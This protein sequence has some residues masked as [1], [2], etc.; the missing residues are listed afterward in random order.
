MILLGLNFEMRDIRIPLMYCI[1]LF[2]YQVSLSCILQS[3]I[4][5]CEQHNGLF[6]FVRYCIIVK[7]EY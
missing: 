5:Y 1:F 4:L 2:F 7:L 6:C 3:I